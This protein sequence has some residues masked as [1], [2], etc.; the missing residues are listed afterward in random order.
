MAFCTA[1]QETEGE[2]NGAFFA[3][4]RSFEL[5][6]VFISTSRTF[7][8]VCMYGKYCNAMSNKSILMFGNMLGSSDYG[9]LILHMSTSSC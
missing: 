3:N 6:L 8:G 9:I 7:Y 5:Y 1:T 4:Y 2:S